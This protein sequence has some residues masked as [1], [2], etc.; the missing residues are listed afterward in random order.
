MPTVDLQKE[1]DNVSQNYYLSRGTLT[2]NIIR[3]SDCLLQHHLI[4]EHRKKVGA[5]KYDNPFPPAN[6]LYLGNVEP[7]QAMKFMRS[8]GLTHLENGASMGLSLSN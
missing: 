7:K 5:I 8:I 4:N 3:Y 2:G 6:Q 1:L